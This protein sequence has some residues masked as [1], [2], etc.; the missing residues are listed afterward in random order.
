MEPMETKMS[1]R[2]MISKLIDSGLRI[3]E[4]ALRVNS[5]ANA[6]YNWKSGLRHPIRIYQMAIEEMYAQKFKA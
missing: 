5:S 3:E 6:V 2:E 4:I 1:H